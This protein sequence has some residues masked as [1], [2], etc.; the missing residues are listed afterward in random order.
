MDDKQRAWYRLFAY[1]FIGIGGVF[2][3]LDLV[4]EL[5]GLSLLRG[6]PLP[7]ALLVMGLG[8]ALV[9]TVRNKDEV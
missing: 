9:W 2:L 3:L 5:F 4:E 6:N 8:F 7:A 1:L